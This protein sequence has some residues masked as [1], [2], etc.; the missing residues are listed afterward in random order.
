MDEKTAARAGALATVR[1][2]PGFWRRIRTG[3]LTKRQLGLLLCLPAFIMILGVVGYPLIYSIYITFHN[4]NFA[5]A[6]LAP[7]FIG[8]KNYARVFQRPDFWKAF[9]RS[10]LFVVYD[11]L[12]GMP[13][14]LAIA[15]LLNQ[16]FKFRGV[17]RA[18]ILLPYVL[19]GTV[20]GLIWKWIYN[21]NHGALNA[22]LHQLGLISD[23]VAWL[24]QPMRA[25]QMVILVNLWQGTPW[26]IIMYLAGLQTIPAEL[27]DA[28][29]VDGA[30]AW[31]T[32]FKVTLPLL[33]PITLAMLV[34]KTVW[35][36]QVFDIVWVLTRGGPASATQVVSYYIYYSSFFQLKFGYAAAMSYVLLGIVLVLV[37]F[38]YRLIRHKVEY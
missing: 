6:G 30:S 14:G 33:S 25:L 36:F 8:L 23:Y 31:Q 32:L 19:S 16:R 21:P 2:R 26:A 27:Y 7:E 5:R 22:L 38:Y 35:T 17:T 34:L 1:R 10:S 24:A 18:T 11:L 3:Q 28:A 4:M 15:L 13:L 9:L 12:A 20:L 29:K 37:F